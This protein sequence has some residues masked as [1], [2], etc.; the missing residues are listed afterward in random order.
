[1]PK[2][3]LNGSAMEDAKAR[4]LYVGFFGLAGRLKHPETLPTTMLTEA[5]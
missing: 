2:G 1:M 4:M 5:V 3:L